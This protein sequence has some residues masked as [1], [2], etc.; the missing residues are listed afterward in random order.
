MFVC[1]LPPEVVSKPKTGR[2]LT[3]LTRKRQREIP[4]KKYWWKQPQVS[5]GRER[6]RKTRL[7]TTF[8]TVIVLLGRAEWS[9]EDIDT[10]STRATRGI[11][12]YISTRMDS[13]W[14]AENGLYEVATARCR[15]MRFR[16]VRPLQIDN[17]CIFNRFGRLD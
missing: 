5:R 13:C 4:T 9:G 11:P 15:R 8:F 2:N 12:M 14:R 6:D 7:C 3:M 17:N 10:A 16:P 1:C